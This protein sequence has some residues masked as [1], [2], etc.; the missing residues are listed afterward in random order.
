MNKL[1][2]I[3]NGNAK[4]GKHISTFSRSYDITCPNSCEYLDNNCY[5]QRIEYRFPSAKK[6]YIN[7]LKIKDWQKIRAFLLEAKKRNNAVRFHVSG[8]FLM[9]SK[10]DRK[11]LD[12]KYINAI[13]QA[14]ESLKKDKIKPPNS[15]CF[16]HVYKIKVAQLSKYIKI[17]ASVQTSGDYK[18]AKKAGFKLFAWSSELVKGK[19]FN[20]IYITET[21]KRVVTCFEQVGTKKDCS[22]CGFCFNS[23]V[24]L[25]ICFLKH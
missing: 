22:S 2:G 21:G 1:I 14:Y 9:T 16:S 24:Q 7:N 17:F 19:D 25:D 3:H 6:S 15:F 12:I 8:D 4:L 20:K 10:N 13:S 18:K 23:N 5:A 11:V